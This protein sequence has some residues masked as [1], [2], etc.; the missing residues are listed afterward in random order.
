VD[1]T[2]AIF[3]LAHAPYPAGSLL[4]LVRGVGQFSG[5]DFTLE[6]ATVTFLSGS[7]PQPGDDI[8]AWHQYLG[9]A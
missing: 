7:I 8:R 1:G 3:T 4:L 2:N 6:D 9:I 5:V